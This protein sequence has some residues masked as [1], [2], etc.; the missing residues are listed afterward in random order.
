MARVGIPYLCAGLL[1]LTVA[2]YLPL[3]RNDFVDFDDELYV[4][5]N[6]HVRG[7]LSGSGF[8]WAW[9]NHDGNYW[10]PIS[11]LT[12]QFDAHYFSGKS[13]EGQTVL[14]PAAFHGHNLFW[15]A[16]SVL[17]LFGLL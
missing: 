11:W 5:A 15:H 12:L 2:A 9:T 10:Q 6:P 8:A 3:W 7:G 17:L 13:P 16:G 4:T 14:S 1:A